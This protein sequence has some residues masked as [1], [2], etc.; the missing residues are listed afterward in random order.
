MKKNNFALLLII[1]FFLLILALFYFFPSFIPPRLK[2]FF[3]SMIGDLLKSDVA[4]SRVEI[5]PFSK[6][7]FKGIKF[8]NIGTDISFVGV[9]KIIVSYDVIKSLKDKRFFLKL[10]TVNKPKLELSKFDNSLLNF[11]GGKNISHPMRIVNGTACYALPSGNELKIEDID[12]SLSTIKDG[13]NVSGSCMFTGAAKGKMSVDGIVSRDSPDLIL[14]LFDFS[15]NDEEFFPLN[16]VNGT[17]ALSG[18]DLVVKKVKF[19]VSDFLFETEGVLKNLTA[20]NPE[21][22]L[23]I[24]GKSDFFKL[25]FNL[26][27]SL[28]DISLKGYFSFRDKR[29]PFLGEGMLDKDGLKIDE[30]R[31]NGVY[32]GTLNCDLRR[33]NYSLFLSS[34]KRS[35]N[36]ELLWDGI[37]YI[38]QFDFQHISVFEKDIVGKGRVKISPSFYSISGDMSYDATLDSDY[39]I[40]NYIP[41][42]NLKLKTLISTG[43]AKKISA[44][45]GDAYSFGGDIYFHNGG[46]IDC[47]L[48]AKNLTLKKGNENTKFFEFF[49]PVDLEADM[50]AV[51]NFK[52]KLFDP[53]ISGTINARNGKFGDITFERGV[54]NF[55]GDKKMLVLSDSKV[56][57]SGAPFRIKGNINFMQK[58]IFNDIVVE[59][60]SK[61][62]V[63]HGWDMVKKEGESSINITKA[64]G[65]N[66]AISLSGA[67]SSGDEDADDKRE[68]SL[69]YN[70]KDGQ[71]LSVDFEDN[72]YED[73]V[74]LK[75]KISF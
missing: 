55:S 47:E 56:Y 42:N 52:G 72:S 9:D 63:W 32:V 31:F 53:Q 34:G 28:N 71:S 19:E 45:W 5:K 11:A 39:I 4:I 22:D 13:L 24:N 15:I 57:H 10:V 54:V 62:I 12:L 65:D 8:D 20:A 3:E 50:D 21:I 27:G 29:Y 66:L 44:E 59:S 26:F 38:I 51:I 73:V 7:V 17:I 61:L 43:Y 40:V 46:K 48:K 37:N 41:F 69:K 14:E 2:A 70:Y 30:L 36:L 75:H 1:A 33:N 74:S 60:V 67:Y 68:A 25:N 49:F 16:K 35:V 6:I 18:E 64:L 23:N 58:N